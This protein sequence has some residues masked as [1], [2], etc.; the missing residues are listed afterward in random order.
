M[1]SENQFKGFSLFTDQDEPLRTRN[2]AVVLANIAED[3]R[4]RDRKINPKGAAI[5]LG[6]FAAIPQDERV[7]LTK[8]FAE[9]MNERGFAIVE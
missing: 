6:Y 9:T 5:M 3:Y 7:A 2:R 4:T 1:N 8:K